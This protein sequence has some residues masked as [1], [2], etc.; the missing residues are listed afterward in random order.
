MENGR[1]KTAAHRTDAEC[2][3]IHYSLFIFSSFIIH[4]LSDSLAVAEQ[5]AV[6]LDAPV[7]PQGEE[8]RHTGQDIPGRRQGDGLTA[9]HQPQRPNGD[10]QCHDEQDVNLAQSLLQLEVTILRDGDQQHH[11]NEAVKCEQEIVRHPP[12]AAAQCAQGEITLVGNEAHYGHKSENGHRD[13]GQE[14]EYRLP[15]L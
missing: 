1:G 3:I 14:Q 12:R 11:H 13:C 6:G 9:L 4:C 15:T 10:E 7:G 2:G 8:E 5:F